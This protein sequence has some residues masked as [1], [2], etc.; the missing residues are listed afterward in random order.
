MWTDGNKKDGEGVKKIGLFILMSIC[1]VLL[2][3]V[4][5]KAV[6]SFYFIDEFYLGCLV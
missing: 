2:I 4:A 5:I 3:L 1:L 6:G